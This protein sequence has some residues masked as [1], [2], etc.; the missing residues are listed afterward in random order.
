MYKVKKDWAGEDQS[1]ERR[2]LNKTL[3][4]KIRIWVCTGS[5]CK[6]HWGQEQSKDR[7]RSFPDGDFGQVTHPPR[8]SGTL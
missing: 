5:N 3:V 1:F 2:A 7:S 6:L 8:L 4:L